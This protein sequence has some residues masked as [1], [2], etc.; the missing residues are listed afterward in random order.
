MH[1]ENTKAKNLSGFD[2]IPRSETEEKSILISTCSSYSLTLFFSS[3]SDGLTLTVTQQWNGWK[4][5]YAK[6]IEND[7]CIQQKNALKY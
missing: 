3:S 6:G 5:R 1:D 2:R 7:V 4:M